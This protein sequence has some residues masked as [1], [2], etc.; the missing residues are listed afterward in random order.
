MNG[1]QLLLSYSPYTYTYTYPFFIRYWTVSYSSTNTYTRT[2]TFC[3]IF[4]SEM[5]VS[6]KN[7]LYIFFLD[8]SAA[9]DTINYSILVNRLTNAYFTCIWNTVFPQWSVLGPIL[10]NIYMVPLFAIID[11]FPNISF[12]SYTDDILIISVLVLHIILSLVHFF[13]NM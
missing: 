6:S 5:F 9:F 12:H 4:K 1:E 3:C 2:K 8:L 10:F 13:A 11:T 7:L